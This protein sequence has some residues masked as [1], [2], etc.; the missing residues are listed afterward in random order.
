MGLD[1][2]DQMPDELNFAM[3]GYMTFM[4]DNGQSFTCEDFRVGQGSYGN[5]FSNHN[6][7]WVGSSD[8]VG[9]SGSH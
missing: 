2:F 3:S 6:N 5:L 7:W 4:F 9:A 8:C 1:Q